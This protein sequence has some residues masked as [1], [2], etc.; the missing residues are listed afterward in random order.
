[1]VDFVRE[2]R[3]QVPPFYKAKAQGTHKSKKRQTQENS[4][5][6]EGVSYRM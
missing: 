6:P 2:N 3:P 5:T 4:L 1:M